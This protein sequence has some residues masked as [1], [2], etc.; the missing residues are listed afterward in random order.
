VLNSRARDLDGGA[1][2]TAHQVVM[3]LDAALAVDRLT[4]VVDQ[5][6]DFAGS[7]QRLQA[8]VHGGEADRDSAMAKIVVKLLG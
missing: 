5:E 7:G 3:M 1:A 2:R 8:S 6:V 4:L